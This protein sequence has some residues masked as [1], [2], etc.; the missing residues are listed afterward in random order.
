MLNPTACRTAPTIQNDL[1]PNV[2]NTKVENSALEL[3]RG[4]V[5]VKHE[6]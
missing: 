5:F 2:K 1:A 4:L 6:G 3:I